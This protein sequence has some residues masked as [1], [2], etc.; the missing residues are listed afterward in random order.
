MTKKGKGIFFHTVSFCDVE[1]FFSSNIKL[2]SLNTP[3]AAQ[4]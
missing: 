2:R 1:R 3:I 4:Y